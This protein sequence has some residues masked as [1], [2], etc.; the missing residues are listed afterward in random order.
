M[1]KNK[2]AT[3]DV[4]YSPF[5]PYDLGDKYQKDATRTRFGTKDEF[6]RMVS[7]LHANG[8][9]VVQDVVLNHTDGAG[10]A[11]GE[12]GKM[13]PSAPILRWARSAATTPGPTV[14]TVFLGTDSLAYVAISTRQH[15]HRQRRAG[16]PQ[17]HHRARC[18]RGRSGGHFAAYRGRPYQPRHFYGRRQALLSDSIHFGNQRLDQPT[19]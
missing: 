6:L 12:A 8:I 1:P 14:R 2:N 18:Y 10:T 3:N 4:G 5:D 9:E 7:V 17:P 15:L 11:T 16:G 19:D 13:P